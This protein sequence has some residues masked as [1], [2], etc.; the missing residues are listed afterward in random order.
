MIILV[1]ALRIIGCILSKCYLSWSRLIVMKLHKMNGSRPQ[2]LILKDYLR[3]QAIEIF[4][5]KIW[6]VKIMQNNKWV[7]VP[8]R[9]RINQMY[10][11]NQNSNQ[12]VPLMEKTTVE[13]N[14]EFKIFKTIDNKILNLLT[15]QETNNSNS[16]LEVVPVLT[17]NL[18]K[19]IQEAN[20]Q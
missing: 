5:S 2:K 17:T 1:Q 14:R 19:T 12:S 8:S 11:A 13:A 9:I 20:R 10:K 4:C 15:L 18:S 16:I 6:W 3:I 7:K